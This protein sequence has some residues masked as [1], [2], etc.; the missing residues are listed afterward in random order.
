MLSQN[1]HKEGHRQLAQGDQLQLRSKNNKL[2]QD[3]KKK[4]N[5][6]KNRIMLLLEGTQPQIRCTEVFRKYREVLKRS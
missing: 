6:R 3:K 2:H 5:F 4:K 1:F